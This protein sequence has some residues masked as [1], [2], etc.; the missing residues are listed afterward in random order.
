MSN[1]EK[2]VTVE[3]RCQAVD[4]VLVGDEVGGGGGGQ[5]LDHSHQVGGA[6]EGDGA[7]TGLLV[8]RALTVVAVEGAAQQRRV[9][10]QQVQDMEEDSGAGQ[11]GRSSHANF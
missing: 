1:S 2:E 6:K 11:G 10:L 8:G 9:G 5:L 7:D 3:A 4:G